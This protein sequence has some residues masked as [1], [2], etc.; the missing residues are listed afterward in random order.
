M[1]LQKGDSLMKSFKLPSDFLMGSATAGA[2]IEG[3]DKNSNWYDWCQ[4]GH[5]RDNTSCFRGDDHWNRYKEDI[6]LM[7]ALHHKIYRLG[8]EWSRIEPQEGKFD[9]EAITHY[10]NEIS[11]LLQRGI[12]PLVT[13]HHFTHPLWLEEKG[14]FEQDGIVGYFARYVRY[15]VENLGDLVSE[16][17]TVNEPNVYATMG[18]Y[19]GVWPPGRKSIGSLRKVLKNM[20]LCHIA[21]YRLIHKIREEMGYPGKTMVGV[22]NHLRIFDPY[23][24]HNPFDR[25]AAGVMGCLFQDAVIKSM[26]TGL[27][28]PPIGFGS[29]KGTG[30][31][32]DFLGINYYTRDAVRFLG[33]QNNVMPDTPRNDLGWE[34]Y[35]E[36][37][38]RLCRRYFEKYPVPIWITENGTCDTNDRFRPRYIYD[39]LLEIAKLCKEGIPIERYYHWSLMDNFEW[40]E[41]ESARFGLVHVDFDNQ[42]RTIRNSGKFFA[43]ICDKLEVT[44]EM[45]QK[46]L[47]SSEQSPANS[48][49]DPL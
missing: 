1:I 38:S 29:P 23:N 47:T 36:G 28:M 5:I 49:P 41:G 27:L 37:L 6:D 8:I 30:R 24:R 33:F 3:G 34:I 9:K 16:Y 46:Y 25:L 18:Y 45:I 43:E 17:I 7:A 2:Q 4:K 13:L 26:S 20:A 39:H 44:G 12:R 22:A 10:R 42:K 21:A 15:A 48:H 19:F 35:P 14:G 32:L 11:L 40:A 31:F